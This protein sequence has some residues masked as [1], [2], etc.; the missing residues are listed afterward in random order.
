MFLIVIIIAF[1]LIVAGLAAI[2]FLGRCLLEKRE[3]I[4]EEEGEDIFDALDR[5]LAAGEIRKDEHE[6]LS[7]LA[8]SRPT[9]VGHGARDKEK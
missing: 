4:Q 8:R 5:R 7:N 2:F 6:R 9:A 3:G 1:L